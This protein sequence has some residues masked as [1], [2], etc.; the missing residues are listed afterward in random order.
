[1]VVGSLSRIAKLFIT[2]L[3]H[4]GIPL[5]LPNCTKVIFLS[6]ADRGS[7]TIRTGNGCFNLSEGKIASE[8]IHSAAIFRHID[9]LDEVLARPALSRPPKFLY[10]YTQTMDIRSAQHT[11]PCCSTFGP[12]S[13]ARPFLSSMSDLCDA[14]SFSRWIKDGHCRNS[15]VAPVFE[16]LFY[17]FWPN[18]SSPTC[19][20]LEKPYPTIS[21]SSASIERFE[22]H[23]L[24]IE[25]LPFY[26][27]SPGVELSQKGLPNDRRACPHPLAIKLVSIHDAGSVQNKCSQL[28]LDLPTKAN[29]RV[30]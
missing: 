3:T 6:A 14:N 4:L 21:P 16:K 15:G 5:F 11:V 17:A 29:M 12:L 24:D 13:R 2:S 25:G 27:Y 26:I 9:K 10:P 7:A 18:D 8:R 20:E 30:P 28:S 22:D 19:C 1:M 23:N